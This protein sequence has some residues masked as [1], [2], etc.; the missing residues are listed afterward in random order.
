[1]LAEV[2]ELHA[3]PGEEVPDRR[4]D[5]D[6]SRFRERED[7]RGRVD[8]DPPD[9]VAL[10]LDLTGV[11]AIARVRPWLVVSSMA[12]AAATARAGLSNTTRNP[13]PVVCTSG[14]RKRGIWARTDWLARPTRRATA[15]SPG[16]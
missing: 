5:D 13:S 4:R 11:N 16:R 14:P 10:E 3:R 9:V 8:G 6:L 12:A 15:Q 1:M 7:P 2:G